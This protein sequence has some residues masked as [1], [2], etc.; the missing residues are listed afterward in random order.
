M[1]LNLKMEYDF[2][3]LYFNL[4]FD[5]KTEEHILF[6]KRNKSGSYFAKTSSNVLYIYSVYSKNKLDIPCNLYVQI[7]WGFEIRIKQGK[8]GDNEY[9]LDFTASCAF[10]Q[11]C[12]LLLSHL[13]NFMFLKQVIYRL[14]IAYF[15]VRKKFV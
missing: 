12:A 14:F 10:G 9:N 11:F 13:F 3:C 5:I 7:S 2:I 15:V 8:L 6:F 1:N 4:S